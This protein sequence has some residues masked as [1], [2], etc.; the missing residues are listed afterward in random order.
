MGC[1]KQTRRFGTKLSNNL[2]LIP[3]V[4]KQCCETCIAAQI[5]KLFEQSLFYP[6]KLEQF[7]LLSFFFNI[8]KKNC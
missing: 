2:A 1:K 5:D 3:T 8:Q 7:I 4:S 6:Q